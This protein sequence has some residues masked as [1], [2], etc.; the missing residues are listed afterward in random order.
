[1]P[2]PPINRTEGTSMTKAELIDA[3]GGQ[4]RGSEKDA[5]EERGPGVD[6]LG[7]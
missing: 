5:G 6:N 2:R 3:V 4:G 7:G 1:M